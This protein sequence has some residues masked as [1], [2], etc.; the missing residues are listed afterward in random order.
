LSGRPAGRLGAAELG[1]YVDPDATYFVCG[2][3]GFA[4][5]ASELLMSL[6]VRP[7][8]VRVERFGPSGT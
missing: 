4:E 6:G 5:S 7:G 3:A 1:P 2:S 8:A